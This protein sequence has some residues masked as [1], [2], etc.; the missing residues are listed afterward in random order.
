MGKG[1]SRSL[2]EIESRLKMRELVREVN[3]GGMEDMR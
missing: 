3:I 1:K 2:E